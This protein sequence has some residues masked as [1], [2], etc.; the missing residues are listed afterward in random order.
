M[1]IPIMTKKNKW[2]A[3]LHWALKNTSII[4]WPHCTFSSLIINGTCLDVSTYQLVYTSYLFS[5]LS[6]LC[7]HTG[8]CGVFISSRFRNHRNN[9]V[10]NLLILTL[11]RFGLR[12]CKLSLACARTLWLVHNWTTKFLCHDLS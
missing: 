2:Q 6:L 9:G 3:K 12:G 8:T 4:T 10:W 5:K 1:L 11:N 7:F